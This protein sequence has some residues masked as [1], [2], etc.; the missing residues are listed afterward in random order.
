[1]KAGRIALWIGMI[2]LVLVLL[3]TLGAVAGF[4][5]G[6]AIYG[7]ELPSN[8]EIKSLPLQVPLR[9]YTAD[10]KLIGEYG[11]ER[12]A[13]V[14]YDDLPQ[15]LIDAFLAAEDER[16]FEHPGVDWR[17]LTRAGVN[18]VLTGRKTQ[19]GSTITM[20][21]ARNYFLSS[22]RT[23]TRK[24]KEILLAL[25]M[26][27]ELGKRLILET[28]LNKIFLGQRA[29]GVGAAAQIYFG[30]TVGELSLSQA[31]VLAGLPKAPSRDN[32]IENP[33]RAQARRDYVLGR[34]LDIGAITRQQY[35]VALAEPVQAEFRPRS[36]DLD[37]HYVAEMAR[38]EAIQ[39]FGED[40]Y[41]GGYSIYTTIDSVRQLAAVAALRDSLQ[42]Y[43]ERHGYPG[44][45][46]A[47]PPEL[48]QQ[49]ARDPA[50][51]RESVSAALA[52]RDSTAGLP[53]AAVVSYTA[54]ALQAML[55][56]GEI[57]AVEGDNLGW[58][59][60][61]D[62]QA[63]HP[64]DV[65][66]LRGF[67]GKWRLAQQPQAQGAF[68]SL[69]PHDG[70][71]QALVG[72]YDYFNGKFNRAIQARRQPGSG[73][74]PFLYTSALSAGYTPASIILDAPVVFDDPQLEDAWRPK[75]DSGR[76]YGP[77]RLREAL[78]YSRNLVSIRLLQAIGINYARDFISRFGFDES[79][80]PRDLTL[81]LGTPTFTPLEM[82]RGYSVFANGG[83]LIDPYW[84]REIRGPHDQILF[85]AEPVVACPECERAEAAAV[86]EDELALA[87]T[88]DSLE[89]VLASMSDA[90][91]AEASPP[92]APRVVDP[93]LIYLADSM[94]IDVARRGT[95][96]RTR[97][98]GRDDIAGKTG[99][100]NDAT[101]AWFFGYHPSLVAVVWIGYDQ[102]TPLGRG[103]YGGRAALP[104]WID[105]M[106]VALDGVPEGVRERPPGL[107]TVRINRETGRLA[108][109]GDPDAIFETVQAEHIPPAGSSGTANPYA[110]D[111]YNP[112]DASS[113]SE[114]E[115]EQQPPPPVEEP[116]VLPGT[117]LF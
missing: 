80:M 1:M 40:A 83:Y 100:T 101:D 67:Q 73:I 41:T 78:V 104:A 32:P 2:L 36:V 49:L 21:L 25:R 112:F 43:H 27:R 23:Y 30:K 115:L 6:Q 99:T 22:E 59:K 5:L 31:A 70:A 47:L 7:D 107:S 24:F 114:P 60:L 109:A 97:Q 86:E 91:P 88:A 55:P 29:Y 87:Q 42:E 13:P 96:A 62:E 89:D 71:L 66:R 116:E 15:R 38:N 110:S 11:A 20:Q 105:Y 34:M 35:E 54:E 53:A 117:G 106:R 92:L 46:S 68:V 37:A 56:S 50:A 17:G 72:G 95:G 84:I 16:F 4:Y 39:R 102:P 82:A 94:M 12:R 3:G 111:P 9:I 45:E 90:P 26:E 8:E 81:A 44:P 108:A 10:G 14:N 58:A 63:L 69:D 79:R 85:E 48:A 33:A 18:L 76:F 65:I 51:A 93:R 77:T 52:G 61:A 103:E 98:L 64:G 28:Y 75:N 57:V 74:K 113:T 19:G